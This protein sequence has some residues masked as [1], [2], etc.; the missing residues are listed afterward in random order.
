MRTLWLLAAIL[1]AAAGVRAAEGTRPMV[2]TITGGQ[3]VECL[4]NDS[5]P[6]PAEHGPYKVEIAGILPA[7][8]NDRKT[9]YLIFTFGLSVAKGAAP[10]HV[11]VE[12]VSGKDT[13]I[14]V[15]DW[16]PVVANG[17]WK[18]SAMPSILSKTST[19]WMF[20]GKPTFKVFKITI[21]GKDSP[22]VVLF[23]PAWYPGQWK[24]GVL[25]FA[26]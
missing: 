7:R 26:K 8:G 1:C 12:D 11:V 22:P 16:N 24:A 20:D 21:S 4:V 10:G 19:P 6:L 13:D 15:D 14:L 9:I 17:H 25:Q 23:Q 2:F 18:G 5:G 3:K